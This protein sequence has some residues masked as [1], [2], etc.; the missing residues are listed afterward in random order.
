MHFYTLYSILVM[1]AIG[2]TAVC[3]VAFA[4]LYA[5]GHWARST[6]SDE[7][8]P[9]IMSARLYALGF[10]FDAKAR[11]WSLATPRTRLLLRTPY[12]KR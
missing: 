4:A 12:P 2:V 10:R 8:V 9:F 1:W 6:R 7:Q 11:A 5:S 3:S